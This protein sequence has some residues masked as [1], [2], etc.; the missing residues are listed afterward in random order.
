MAEGNEFAG[1]TKAITQGEWAGWR[2]WGAD[3]FEDMTGPFVYRVEEGGKV[4]CAFKA[5]KQH[6]N[7]GGFMHGGCLKTFADYAMFCIATEELAGGGAGAPSFTSE[8][9]PTAEGGGPIGGT[10]EVRQAGK[11]RGF[12]GGGG[13]YGGGEGR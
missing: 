2:N 10:G 7:G 6:M 11:Q 1:G 5:G 8:V 13:F 3:A 9:I 12:C 4:R